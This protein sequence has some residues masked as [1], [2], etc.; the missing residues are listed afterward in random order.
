MLRGDEALQAVEEWV[1]GLR[2]E[3]SYKKALRGAEDVVALDEGRA[4]IQPRSLRGVDVAP[5]GF[6][7]VKIRGK[8]VYIEA[9]Y[10]SFRVKDLV[11]RN[12]EPTCIPA[13]KGG[14][15]SIKQFYRWVSDNISKI[16]SM[17]YYD[18]LGEMR[19]E[20]INYHDYCA[21]D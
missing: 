12:N 18:V 10:D 15:K 8:H 13:F 5:A 1:D 21:M 19:K 4:K 7:P 20:G 14:K 17:K 6:K 9:D 2:R 16:K 3:R 11:D